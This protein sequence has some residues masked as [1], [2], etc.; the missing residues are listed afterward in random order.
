MNDRSPFAPGDSILHFTLQELVAETRSG[1]TWKALDQKT[2]HTVALKILAHSL[3]EDPARRQQTFQRIKTVAGVRTASVAGL[4]GFEQGDGRFV[5]VMEWVDSAPLGAI[6]EI[7]PFE[8]P[9]FLTEAIKLTETFE[10]FRIAGFADLRVHA[11][12]VRLTPLRQLKFLGLGLGDNLF[13]FE[14]TTP[15]IPESTQGSVYLSPEQIVGKGGDERSLVFSLGSLFYQLLTGHVPFEASAAEDVLRKIVREPPASPHTHRKGLDPRLTS[16]LAR[17][18]HKDPAKRVLQLTRLVEELKSIQGGR[19][20]VPPAKTTAPSVEAAVPNPATKPARPATPSTPAAPAASPVPSVAPRPVPP[21]PAPTAQPPSPRL[22]VPAA[23]P[24]PPATQ[25]AATSPDP[26]IPVTATP[27]P[28]VAPPQRAKPSDETPKPENRPT[29]EPGGEPDSVVLIADL[30][31]FSAMARSNIELASKLAA[32]MQQILSE[33]VFLYDGKIIDPFGPRVVAQLESVELALNAFAKA[34][35]DEKDYNRSAPKDLILRIRHVLHFGPVKVTRSEISGPAVEAALSAIQSAPVGQLVISREAVSALGWTPPQKVLGTFGGVEFLE[36]IPEKPKPVVIAPPVA[37]PVVATPP[38]RRIPVL[39]IGAGAAALVMIVLAVILL[40]RS[41]SAREEAARRA[42]EAARRMPAPVAAPVAV[43]TRVVVDPFTSQTTDAATA[44]ELDRLGAVIR[45][46][47]LSV[48]SIEVGSPAGSDARI[49]GMVRPGAG[50]LEIVPL[51]TRGSETNEGPVFPFKTAIGSL[52][53]LA[54]WMRIQLKIQRSLIS[55]NPLANEKFA[56]ASLL[57]RDKHKADPAI[58]NALNASLVA[59]PGFIAAN[60]LAFEYSEATENVAGAAEAGRQLLQNDPENLDLLRKVARYQTRSGRSAESVGNW[61]RLLAKVPGDRESLLALLGAALSAGHAEA[62]QKLVP[63][64]GKDSPFHA[65]DLLLSNGRIDAAASQYFTLEA[66]DPTSPSLALKIGTV[67]V[68]RRSMPIAE[69][70]LKKLEQSDPA[71]GRPLLHSYILAQN[72]GRE[73]SMKEWAT[74]SLG[75]RQGQD[76]PYTALAE[77]E[78]MFGNSNGLLAALQ[79]AV[80][81]GEPT[82]NYIL[83]NPLFRYLNSDPRFLEI[84]A[85]A[86]AEKNAIAEQLR[87]I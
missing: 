4:R 60:Q 54:Q 26:V 9:A 46:L 12:E 32:K 64:L 42:A 2:Q 52:P 31:E 67:S 3:F 30:P 49:S 47:L 37:E 41:R 11:D 17:T 50:G 15:P 71:Y 61:K 74:A 14:G 73:E 81:R 28:A 62:F 45:Q 33:A 27:I 79:K 10:A 39:A 82:L 44:K 36:G 83:H 13:S 76:A 85:A 16:I 69:L 34:R 87:G 66:A 23:S 65:P 48:P 78:A 18:L 72:G 40:G 19:P 35:E 55:D 38:P 5:V 58:E 6:V 25:P 57:W 1:P 70:E 84:K 63:Q 20:A 22:N 7:D 56:E 86:E 29:Q 80:S 53:D 51:L 75:M 77:I 8:S 21:V 24:P 43:R 59:D 68:L